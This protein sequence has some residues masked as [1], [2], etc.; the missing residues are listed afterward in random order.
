[1]TPPSLRSLGTGLIA[2]SFLCGLVSAGLWS[3]STAAWQ[4]HLTRASETG[5]ALYETLRRGG[6]LPDGVSLTPL[7]AADAARAEQGRFLELP[8]LPAPAHVTHAS[9][10]DPGPDPTARETMA[11]IIVS[12]QLR[13]PI[14][15]LDLGQS[16]TAAQKLGAITR[17]MATYCSD[18]VLLARRADGDWLR[19]DGG[20]L[21]SCDA[22]PS[23]LRLPAVLLA[24]VVLAVLVSR[25]IATAALFESFA[26]ALQGRRRLGGPDAYSSQGPAELREIVAAVNT[27]LEVEQDQIA[28]RA[29]VLSAVSH[30]LGT[31][32]TRLRLRTALIQDPALRDKLDADI[33]SMTGMIDS[34]LTYTRSEMNVEEPRRLSLT[35]FIEAIVADYQDTGEPVTLAPQERPV[36][37]GGRSVF[38][39]VAGHGSVPPGQP[40]L[41][42]ARPVSLK[43]A[44]ENLID[45]AL[46][47]G[48]RAH[49]ALSANADHGIITVEDEG[50]DLSTQDME[51]II[52]PFQRGANAAG[53]TG[54]GLGLTIVATVAEQ[55]GG[56]LSFES[57]PKGLRA[58]LEICR[59]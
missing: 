58:R 8:D 24:A 57:G 30:D 9:I 49:V 1:M 13:Y 35:S 56:S 32:A 27:Y 12:D 53:V 23:D 28:K 19:I 40:I 59:N 2:V 14:A 34:V 37:T 42:M 22:Q 4:R 43:R 51:A 45:N 3:S 41:V 10:F 21:W 39:G 11:L 55:H 29:T 15:D 50:S 54:F 31:P 5:F 44:V 36:M 46:K 17:L 16:I 18:P 20:R 6:A 47:Y 25:V 52:G 26:R 7:P 48:R 38:S 33:D